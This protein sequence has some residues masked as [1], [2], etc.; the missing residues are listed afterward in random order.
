MSREVTF[1]GESLKKIEEL[2]TFNSLTREEK[3]M[4]NL[5]SVILH[6]SL[7]YRQKRQINLSVL[8]FNIKRH[9]RK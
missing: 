8:M 7:D 6:D 3:K 5:I 4:L 9:L 1:K 2:G